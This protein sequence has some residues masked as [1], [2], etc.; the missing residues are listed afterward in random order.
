LSWNLVPAIYVV[1][2]YGTGDY[3]TIQATVT[4]ADDGD[5]IELTDGTFTGD[6]NRDVVYLG[7]RTPSDSGIVV[8]CVLGYRAQRGHDDTTT[9]I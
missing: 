8:R 3:P 5:I 6:G 4:A 2:P 1:H 7:S 9:W